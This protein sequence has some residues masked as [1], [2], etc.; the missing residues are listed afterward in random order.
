MLSLPYGTLNVTKPLELNAYAKVNLGLN[1]VAKRGDGYHE[2]DTLMTK[3][4]VFDVVRLEPAS[5]TTLDVQDADLGEQE[6]N[7]AFRAARLYFEVTQQDKGVHI[8]LE[9]RIP[10]AAGLGGGSSD[11]GA[12]LRGL[13]QLYPADN[14]DLFQLAKALGSDVPF[15]VSNLSA[16]RARGR[17]EKLEA[18]NLPELHLILLNPGVE[19]SAKSAYENLQNFSPRLKL[20]DLLKNLQAGE[21]PGYLNALQP[22]VMLHEP[23]IREVITALRLEGLRGVMMSGSGSTCFGLA[24]DEAH[25]GEVEPKFKEMYPSWWVEAVRTL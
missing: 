7:L 17:G 16:A 4:S 2:V 12:V 20:D 19:V 10:V 24:R 22:G 6:D 11:A 18:V 25:A 1:V 5:T 8:T 23:Y 14:I 15:F 9:K 13:S 3:V 21:E